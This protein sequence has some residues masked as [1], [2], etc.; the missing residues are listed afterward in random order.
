M[1]TFNVPEAFKTAIT[2]GVT[3]DGASYTA[4]IAWNVYGQRNYITITDQYG[5]VVVTLPLI[6]SVQSTTYSFSES[7]FTQTTQNKTNTLALIGPINIIAGYFQTS[8]MYY[9]PSDQTLVVTP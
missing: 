5:N 1:T 2:L 4:T 7:N 6:G 3:L 9:F 8:T